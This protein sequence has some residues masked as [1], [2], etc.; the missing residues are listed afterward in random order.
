MALAH[1]I[2]LAA[3][4]SAKLVTMT[5]NPAFFADANLARQHQSER[6]K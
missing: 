5:R 1:Y 2:K 4:C 3:A 6:T